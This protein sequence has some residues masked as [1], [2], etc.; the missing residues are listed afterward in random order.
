MLEKSLSSLGFSPSET[1]IYLHLLKKGCSYANKISFETRLN[2]TNVYEALDRLI[3]KGVVSF[4]TRNKVKWHEAKSPEKILKL[5]SLKEDELNKIKGNLSEEIKEFKKLINPDKK[6]LEANIFIGKKG[7]R[8]L[9]EEILEAKKPISLIASELQFKDFFGAYF[10]LWHKK[11]IERKIRQRTIFPIKFKNNVKKKGLLSYKFVD[12]KFTS[13]TTTIIYG[14]N[15][16][17][18]QW[19]KEPLAI[20]I[21]NEEITKSHLNYFDMLWKA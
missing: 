12:N 1:K 11:R 15:C 16:L 5:I 6:M 14:E 17:F 10:E 9:F 4:V 3:A 18:I 7:L 20:K 21:Q 8:M 13:P 19:S 2:R